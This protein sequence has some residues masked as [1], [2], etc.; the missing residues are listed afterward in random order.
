MRVGTRASRWSWRR[1]AGEASRSNREGRCR[2]EG[3]RYSYRSCCL[4]RGY[5][6]P[7]EIRRRP[8][9]HLYY[10]LSLTT[11]RAQAAVEG[12]R[13]SHRSGFI[14][15]EIAAALHTNKVRVTMIY[16]GATWCAGLP[17]TSPI[18]FRRAIATGASPS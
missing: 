5:A 2:S 16:P 7:A 17:V 1:H 4:L 18:P 11:G 13:G 10:A 12:P 9:R 15:S 8:G 3:T 14:G 6:A